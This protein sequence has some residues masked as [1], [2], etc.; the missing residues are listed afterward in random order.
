M[1][2]SK[3]NSEGYYDPVPHE[4]VANIEKE[5]RVWKP[6]IYVCSPYSGDVEGNTERARKFCRFAVDAGAIPLAP[7]LLLPQFMSEEFERDAAMFMNMV[8]LGR[9]EELWVFGDDI[10]SGMTA[11][12]NKAEKRQMKI[13]YFTE[14]CK[15]KKDG[16]KR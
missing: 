9:C 16:I 7:H 13:R 3:F 14:E 2:I 1:G 10:T 11:E 8:F 4:A 5:Q 6:L 12:I 15:E